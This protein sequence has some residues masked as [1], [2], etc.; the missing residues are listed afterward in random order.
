MV[1]VSILLAL[2]IAASV[3]ATVA[4]GQEV[5]VALGIL[6]TKIKVLLAQVFRLK[7]PIVLGWFKVQLSIFL[8]KSLLSTWLSKH[9]LPLLVGAALLRR[10]RGVLGR[11]TGVLKAHFAALRAWYAGLGRWLRIAVGLCLVMALVAL[12]VTSLGLWLVLFS[13]QVPLWLAAAVSSLAVTVWASIQKKV[14]MSLAFLKLGWLW[15]LM[16]GRLPP[17]LLRWK[18]RMD[19]RL[20]R[21]VV[22]RR[23]AAQRRLAATRARLAKTRL[24]QRALWRTDGLPTDDAQPS[25]E[26]ARPP[27]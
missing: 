2:V 25:A 16:H 22:R 7:L 9:I 6:V 21:V 8:R 10:V 18:R 19:F 23:R 17:S 27:P 12:S 24:A 15:R 5:L 13:V 3:A 4:F 26:T 1:R 14:F 20:A 11:Y